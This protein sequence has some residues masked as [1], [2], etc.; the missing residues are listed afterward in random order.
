MSAAPATDLLAA[1]TAE[2]TE[3]AGLLAALDAAA[4]DLPTPCTRWTVR[5]VAVHVISYDDLGTPARR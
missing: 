3:L 1:A 5:D 4:W 2:R